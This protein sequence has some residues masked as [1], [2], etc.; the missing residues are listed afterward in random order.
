PAIRDARLGVLAVAAPVGRDVSGVADREHVDVRCDAEGVDDLEGGR[1]LSL[2]PQRVD[3]VDQGDRVAGRQLAGEPKAVVEPPAY[4]DDG[5][6]VDDGL[7][8]LARGDTALR[9]EDDR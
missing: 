7:S 3:R 8:H 5:G 1:L 9:N 2:E 4:L 6:T